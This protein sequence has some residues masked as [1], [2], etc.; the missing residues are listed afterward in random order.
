MVTR[1][2]FL[3]LG[4]SALTLPVFNAAGVTLPARPDGRLVVL[5]LRGG[6]DGLFGFSPVADTHLSQW[7]PTLSKSILADGVRLGGTGFAAHS[8]CKPL[9]DL[10]A[11]GE[12]SFAPCAGTTDA[13]RSHF[14]A[15][16]LFELG[17][18]APHGK[19]GFMA[20]AAR[21][22]SQGA[23]SFTND[24]PLCFQG[25]EG[26]QVAPLS[27][28]GL[29]LPEGRLLDAIR[30]AHRGWDTGVALE[31]ALATEADIE[32]AMSKGMDLTAA[33]GAPAAKGFAAS[34]AQMGRILRGNPR[35]GLTFLDLGGWDTHAGEEGALSRNL[36]A[37]SEGVVALKDALG[38]VEWRRTRLAI[39][40][41]FGRTVREN[42]TGGTD[43]GHG[44]LF[45]LA[46]GAINGGKMLGAFD[47]LAEDALNE[48][49]DLPVSAD[50][51]ALLGACMAETYGLGSAALDKIF[52]GRPAQQFQV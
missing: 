29:K 28:S 32:A 6:M 33:R 4:G 46:G 12:L 42:G 13:S 15:Q 50:W 49:R 21:I 40:S 31:Q 30:S 39:M 23:I 10:F 2:Q 24:V 25:G 11:A 9:A 27:G 47:G 51:R 8:S 34:A 48:N 19:T 41:E 26:V 38:D 35:L 17:S 45:L 1:R 18:G 37:L 36:Q 5:L 22:L 44:G 16:D 7:R 3:A 20:R 14:Q 52:P 43:H